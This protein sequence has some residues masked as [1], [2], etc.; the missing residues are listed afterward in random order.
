[1]INRRN[2][3]RTGA[4]TAGV[5]GLGSAASSEEL[6]GGP[7][8]FP[9]FRYALPDFPAGSRLLFQAVSAKWPRK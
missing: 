7:T 3:F 9:G 8:D 2:L 4:I 6:A 5:V 1:M